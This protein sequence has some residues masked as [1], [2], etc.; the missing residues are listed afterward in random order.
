[1]LTLYNN[2]LSQDHPR[3]KDGVKIGVDVCEGLCRLLLPSG[4]YHMVDIAQ[5]EP[6]ARL[7]Q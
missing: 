2:V 3:T 5:P 7:A 1:M 4:H 6:Y